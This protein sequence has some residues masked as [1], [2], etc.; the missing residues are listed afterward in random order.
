[1]QQLL[2]ER[3][4]VEIEEVEASSAL[5]LLWMEEPS[6]F[7][8]ANTV[9]AWRKAMQEELKCIEENGTWELTSLPSGQKPIGLKWGFKLKK[10][11]AGII[12]KHKARLIA[13]GHVQTQGIDFEEV[14]A[15]VARMETMRMFLGIAE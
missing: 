12:V 10:D 4:E 2:D 11:R 9:A 7:Q 15:P 13:K 1:V 8:E 5:R 6:T 3:E 14:Y